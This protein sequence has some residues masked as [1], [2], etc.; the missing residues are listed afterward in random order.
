MKILQNKA[1]NYATHLALRN[2]A[3]V[4]L[5]EITAELGRARSHA[6]SS[7]TGAEYTGGEIA[8]KI[9]FR[10]G[11]YATEA[12]RFGVK[13]H[14][15]QLI[16]EVKPSARSVGHRRR[17]EVAEQQ[18]EELKSREQILDDANQSVRD[19][20]AAKN[21]A[22]K[23]LEK[24]QAKKPP[25]D[26]AALKAVKSEIEKSTAEQ[27]RISGK[28]SQLR[29]TLEEAGGLSPDTSHLDKLQAEAALGG[30]D[31]G[32][33]AS[34]LSGA[35]KEAQSAQDVIDTLEAQIRGLE[36]ILTQGQENLQSLEETGKDIGQKVHGTANAIA[37]AKLLAHF[38]GTDVIIQEL[39]DS[40]HDLNGS[41][42]D[43]QEYS[44]AKVEVRL[45]TI[46]SGT[47]LPETSPY[48]TLRD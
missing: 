45:P 4:K 19:L 44:T 10:S 37:E 8:A 16:N 9:G 24:V 34:A 46:Y 26:L 7:R 47:G 42:P 36:G 17:V 3:Q 40:R 35:K 15:K 22:E 2:A 41:L 11:T 39:N 12:E 5:A 43:G 30:E 18:L 38:K 6:K 32:G 13:R 21:K 29:S 1:K 25:A 28:L 31:S 20:E 14:L 23:E 27:D 33:I 48:L